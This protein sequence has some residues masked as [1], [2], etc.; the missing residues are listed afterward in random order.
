M[1]AAR[2]RSLRR[3][4]QLC[5]GDH[6]R[7]VDP[8]ISSSVVTPVVGWVVPAFADHIGIIRRAISLTDETLT[9]LLHFG[10]VG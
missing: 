2:T 3:P 8:T 10:P 6:D 7:M 9:K 5:C 4:S 1:F